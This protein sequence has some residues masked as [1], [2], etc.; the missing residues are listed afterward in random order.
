MLRELQMTTNSLD[1]WGEPITGRTAD[2]NTPPE[3]LDSIKEMLAS[4]GVD[5]STMIEDVEKYSFKCII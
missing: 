3:L 1:F 4:K 5:V 2:I